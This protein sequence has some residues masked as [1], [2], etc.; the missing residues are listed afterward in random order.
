MYIRNLAHGIIPLG[1]AKKERTIQSDDIFA[2]S[3]VRFLWLVPGLQ[4]T[5]RVREVQ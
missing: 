4:D 5:S 3:Q 2:R 1:Y